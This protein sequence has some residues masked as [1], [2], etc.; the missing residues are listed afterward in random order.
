VIDQETLAKAYRRLFLTDDGEIVLTDL[1][2]ACYGYKNMIDF[3]RSERVYYNEG[4]RN[5]YLHILDMVGI[6]DVREITRALR[7]CRITGDVAQATA[8]F[9]GGNE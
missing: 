6:N 3:Q 9:E 1:A 4:L 7:N 2:E 5:A 8:E